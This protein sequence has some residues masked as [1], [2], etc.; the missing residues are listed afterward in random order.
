MG[1]ATPTTTVAAGGSQALNDYVMVSFHA[2]YLHPSYALGM[3]LVSSPFDGKGFGGWKRAMLIALSAK[4]KIGFIDGNLPK[5]AAAPLLNAWTRCNGTVL[6]WL[7][8]SLSKDIAESV[9]YSHSDQYLWEDLEARYGQTNGQTLPTTK[10]IISN[11]Q[12]F[13]RKP[14]YQ[15]RKGARDGKNNIANKEVSCAYCKKVRHTIDH[16]YKLHG[17]PFD[18]K[19]TKQRQPYQGAPRANVV[20]SSEAPEGKGALAQIMQL[21]Q[22]VKFEQSSTSPLDG[23]LNTNCAGS[24]S[25]EPSGSW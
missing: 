12:N 15:G 17:F 5:P 6:S 8:N 7:L 13:N 16:C 25:E 9:L 3:V 10:E 23:S 2:Y 20:V 21:L 22:Q 19:F 11:W 4:N 14:P 24:F 18:F 1:N